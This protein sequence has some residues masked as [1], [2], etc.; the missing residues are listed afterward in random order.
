MDE[1]SGIDAA[2][3][4]AGGP[5]RLAD[6]LGESVQTVSNW[7]ARGAVPAH[8]C[9]AVEAATG[10][11]R[12]RLRPRDWRDYWPPQPASRQNDA[13]ESPAAARTPSTLGLRGD[14]RSGAER[15]HERKPCPRERRADERRKGPQ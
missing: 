15:R 3:T 2:I 4:I 6:Q 9:A 13:I 12:R 14:W 10:V 1:K 5:K 7:R 11:D 8:R